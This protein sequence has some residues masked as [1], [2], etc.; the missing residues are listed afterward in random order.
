MRSWSVRG[1]GLATHPAMASATA[2]PNSGKY[3]CVERG[4]ARCL[5]ATSTG[6][7]RPNEPHAPHRVYYVVEA[8][9]RLA[10]FLEP[11]LATEHGKPPAAT[12][13]RRAISFRYRL[14]LSAPPR[15]SKYRCVNNISAELSRPGNT[16]ALSVNVIDTPS[17]LFGVAPKFDTRAGNLRLQGRPSSL[18]CDISAVAINHNIFVRRTSCPGLTVIVLIVTKALSYA[19]DRGSWTSTRSQGPRQ[20]G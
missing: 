8:T 9:V 14:W 1:I 6:R 3:H 13:L 12:L 11:T 4:C 7:L 20:R 5:C 17:Q 2:A 10:G 16:A 19:A 18:I 15:Q